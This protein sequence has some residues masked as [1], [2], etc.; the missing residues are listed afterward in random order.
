MLLID[1]LNDR[2]QRE[3]LSDECEITNGGHACQY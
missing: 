3:F 2:K 1:P